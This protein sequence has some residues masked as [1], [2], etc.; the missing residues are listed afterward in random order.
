[1]KDKKNLIFKQNNNLATLS[2]TSDSYIF[3]TEYVSAK[4]SKVDFIMSLNFRT[5]CLKKFISARLRRWLS[6]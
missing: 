3:E 5:P 1:M 6:C 2:V 4:F